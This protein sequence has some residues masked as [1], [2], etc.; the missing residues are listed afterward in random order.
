MVS[1]VQWKPFW[2]ATQLFPQNDWAGFAIL[3]EDCCIRTDAIVGASITYTVCWSTM[4]L[5][6]DDTIHRVFA[7]ERRQLRKRSSDLEVL[8]DDR[9]VGRESRPY[10]CMQ[11]PYQ[12]VVPAKV[13]DLRPSPSFTKSSMVKRVDWLVSFECHPPLFALLSTLYLQLSQKWRQW[14]SEKISVLS[15]QSVQPS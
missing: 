3:C 11:E 4:P 5:S 6:G 15:L 7:C 10:L 14:R 12:S 13:R 9:R 1:K 2:L 8:W